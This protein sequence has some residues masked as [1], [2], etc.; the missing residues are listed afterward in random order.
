MH[1]TYKGYIGHATWDDEAKLFHGNVE[2]KK[3]IVT[4]QGAN[5]QELEQALKDSIDDYLE[6]CQKLGELP[7]RPFSNIN[8]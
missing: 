3:D 6:F 1:F 7:E 8:C 4:F 2:L 5:A